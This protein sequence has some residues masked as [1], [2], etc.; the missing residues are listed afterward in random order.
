MGGSRLGFLVL[1]IADIEHETQ[2]ALRLPADQRLALNTKPKGFLRGV[3]LRQTHA[4]QQWRAFV[5]QLGE[6]AGKLL[7]VCRMNHRQPVL[8]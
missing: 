5:T 6:T 4:E 3:T 7:A 1:D 2:H 8:T